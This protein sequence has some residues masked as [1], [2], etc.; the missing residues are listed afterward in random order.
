MERKLKIFFVTPEIFFGMLFNKEIHLRVTNG[1]PEDAKIVGK[2]Y[3]FEHDRFWFQIASDL[4]PEVVEGARI[5]IG[6]PA[7]FHFIK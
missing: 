6:D 1:L 2:G 3:D 4:F 7:T 5:P